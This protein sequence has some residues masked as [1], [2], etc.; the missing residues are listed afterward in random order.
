VRFD[1]II[2][3]DEQTGPYYFA[4]LRYPPPLLQ[5]RSSE[6]DMTKV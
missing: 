1:Y 6:T 4:W 2:R 3:I 5:R